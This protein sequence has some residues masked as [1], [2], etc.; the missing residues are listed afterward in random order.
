LPSEIQSAGCL[1][2]SVP[3]PSTIAS[4]WLQWHDFAPSEF[5]L[6]P[7]LRHFGPVKLKTR[8]RFIFDHETH[9]ESELSKAVHEAWDILPDTVRQLMLF[10]WAGVHSV[11]SIRNDVAHPDLR[12]STAKEI[13]DHDFHNTFQ[14]L[15]AAAC[16]IADYLFDG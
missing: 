1:T 14:N 4:W 15:H 13:L 2:F 8:A 9:Q 6:P 7:P 12:N 10:S 11:R 16:Y 5:L 3:V